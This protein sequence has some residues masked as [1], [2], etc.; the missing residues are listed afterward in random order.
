MIDTVVL[1]KGVD[2]VIPF[3]NSEELARRSG[4]TWVEVDADHRL[5]DPEPLVAMSRAYEEENG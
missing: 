2:D 3:A 1:Y 4:A 5:A